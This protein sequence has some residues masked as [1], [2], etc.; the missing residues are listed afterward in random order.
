VKKR[1]GLVAVLALGALIAASCGGDDDDSS[2]AAT[3]AAGGATTTAASGGATTTAGGGGATTTAAVPSG[4]AEKV[5][6]GLLVEQSGPAAAVG[7]AATDA[8]QLAVA[9]LNETGFVVDGKKYEFELVAKDNKT[10][11]AAGVAAATELVE[12]EGVKFLFGPTTSSIAPGVAQLVLPQGVLM[13][14]PATALQAELTPEKIEGPSKTLF[15]TN[16]SPEGIQV[17]QGKATAE[18]F[19][20]AKTMALVTSDD[21][22]SKQT[23]PL[24]KQ[25]AE[26]LGIEI[27]ADE[28]FPAASTDFQTVLTKAKDANPDVLYTCCTTPNDTGVIRQAIELGMTSQIFYPNQPI[29]ILLEG[30]IGKPVPVRG[31]VVYQPV[32]LET[33]PKGELLTT[34]EGTKKFAEDLKTVLGKDVTAASGIGFYYY[35]WIGLLAKAMEQAGTVEDTEAIAEALQ[36]GVSVEGA[37]GTV[38]FTEG[39]VSNASGDLCINEANSDTPTCQ[40]LGPPDA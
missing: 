25:A 7:G 9:L 6:I 3:T 40:E 38:A 21:G 14:T 39:H 15:R 24:Q 10:D 22:S 31:A 20:D 23:T 2:G 30:A 27:V 26:D 28:T 8:A 32:V 34:R 1:K 17:M 13:F 11:P 35:D 33:T 19:P 16:W 37:I 36:S 5:K 12:D 4:P 29:S 18:A